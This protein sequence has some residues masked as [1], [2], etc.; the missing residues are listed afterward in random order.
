MSLLEDF[1]VATEFTGFQTFAWR[2]I[3]RRFYGRK[4]KNK[5]FNLRP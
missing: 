4:D 1:S 2:I 3:P 5:T